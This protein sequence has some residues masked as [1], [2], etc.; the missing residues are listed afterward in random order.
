MRVS[1]IVP[2]LAVLGMLLV[3]PGVASAAGPPAATTGTATAIGSTS[4]TLNGTVSA[5]KQSTTVLFQYGTTTAYG[6][7]YGVPAGAGTVNGNSAKS[8]SAAI[9]GLT[10]K[11]LYHFR[12]TAT[13]ASGQSIGQ[14]MTFTTT[15]ASPPPPP[16]KNAVGIAAVPGTV[17]YGRSAV[18]SGRVTGPKS[19]GAQV[20]LQAQPYPFTAP[21]KATGAVTSAASNGRYSFTVAP[22]LRTRYQV[23]AKTAPPVTSVAVTIS[24]RYAVSFFVS[25]AIVH[26]GA[27][28]RFFG[29]IR[30]A[31][32][33]RTVYIQRRSS[34]GV[35]HTVAK[36]VLLR[37][38]SS[39]RSSYSK[40]LRIFASGIYRVRILR[41]A[42]YSASNSSS[43][44]ITVR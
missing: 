32:N 40:R 23:V 38:T 43:R 36:T 4:A 5:N 14:D 41:H 10:P 17:T 15:A 35:Y 26:R 16:A 7:P 25:H 3:V 33:G 22:R 20:T 8:V 39:T 42:A 19:G 12:V 18:I 21:F 24:V 31:A 34:T 29:S 9:S 30:P 2:V 28:V 11:T 27:L 37:T 13:N 1:R 6:G 44:R